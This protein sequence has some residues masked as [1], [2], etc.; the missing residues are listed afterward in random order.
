MQRWIARTSRPGGGRDWLR[1][2]TALVVLGA[3]CLP[4][5]AGLHFIE[6]QDLRLVYYDPEE[7]HLVPHAA[8]SFLS[9]LAT[10]KRLFDYVPYD[11]VDVLL[12][13]FSDRGNASTLPAP[14]NRIFVDNPIEAF[15][16]PPVRG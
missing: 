2:V 14:R 8:Q 9:G 12:Q 11:R 7:T 13:D 4:A 3:A 16:F 15:G 1:L 6:T 5:R 10:Y